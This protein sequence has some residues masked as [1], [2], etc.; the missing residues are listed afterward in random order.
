VSNKN[1]IEYKIYLGVFAFEKSYECVD[2]LVKDVQHN[3]D[4]LLFEEMTN[5]EEFCAALC[6]GDWSKVK[7]IREQLI[8]KIIEFKKG[9]VV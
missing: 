7:R 3:S 6:L 5:N 8:E 2:D 4:G 1:S 9:L